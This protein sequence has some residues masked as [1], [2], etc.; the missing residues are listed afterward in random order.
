MVLSAIEQRQRLYLAES[1]DG[2]QWELAA[3]PLLDDPRWSLLDPTLLPL[4]RD[5][6]RVYYTRSRGSVYELRSAVLSRRAA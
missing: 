3:E 6:Y 4:G 5:R 2:L 1:E